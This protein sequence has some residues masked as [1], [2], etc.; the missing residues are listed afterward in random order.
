MKRRD[1]SGTAKTTRA[2]TGG[3]LPLPLH[4]YTQTRHSCDAAVHVIIAW[5][6]VEL[7]WLNSMLR[8]YHIRTLPN[9]ITFASISHL[10]EGRGALQHTAMKMY[11]VRKRPSRINEQSLRWACVPFSLAA[12]LRERQRPTMLQPRGRQKPVLGKLART[13][14]CPLPRTRSMTSS[15]STTVC[16]AP[17][18][19]Y[20]L[21]QG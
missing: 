20:F 12:R 21:A 9:K 13:L 11:R 10:Y 1:L 16:V 6:H 5:N 19:N 17:A 4:Q 7:T 2:G 14:N 18:M 3:R 8:S 15:L